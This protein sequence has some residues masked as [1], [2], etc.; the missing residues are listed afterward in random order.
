MCSAC[1]SRAAPEK[2][3]ATLH[4]TVHLKANGILA[5][6]VVRSGMDEAQGVGRE[7]G[8]P[9]VHDE[10]LLRYNDLHQSHVVM[11]MEVE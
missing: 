6:V 10:Q 2:D 4:S 8:V 1:N 5:L 9:A 11:H 7:E 3:H